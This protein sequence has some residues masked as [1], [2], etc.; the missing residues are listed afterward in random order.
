VQ[1]DAYVG[2]IARGAGIGSFGIGIGQVLRYAIQVVLAKMYG[3]A[4]L[5][6]Y[7]LGVT[8]VQAA[9]SLSQL[10]I[11]HG[12]I[13]YTAEYRARRDVSRMRGTIL[14]GLWVT[15]ALSLVLACLIFFSAGILADRIFSKPFLETIFRAFS[16]AVPFFAAMSMALS[17]TQGFQTVKYRT[18]VQH[19]LQPLIALGLIVVFYLLGM[20]LFGAVAAYVLSMAAGLV[21]SLHYLKQLFP[22]LLDRE[23]PPEFE[24]RALFSVAGPMS[25]VGLAQWV[26][27]GG[28]VL[29]VGIFATAGEVG[30]YNA[31]AGTGA[32]P[33]LVLTAFSGIF[34]PMISDLYSRGMLNDLGLLYRDVSRW[35]FTGSLAIFLLTLLLARDIMAMFGAEFVVG[36]L[37]M[38]LIAGA[39]LFSCSVGPTSRILV[40]T[41]RQKTLMVTMLGST[42][43]VLIANVVLVPLYGILG[44]AL[45]RAAGLVLL[46]AVA[47]LFVHRLLRLWPYNKHYLK[48]L[49]AGIIGVAATLLVRLMLPLPGALLPILVLGPLF[50]AGFIATLLV[51]GLSVSDRKLLRALWT[52]VLRTTLWRSS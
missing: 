21:L 19:V 52:M 15:F 25:V 18:Y 13:R 26:N 28:T 46:N 40:M 20:Q 33:V 12:V 29:V 41:D 6:F 36:W 35:I 1:Y 31:A 2:R 17:A 23:V 10:G 3:P 38:V 44:A 7:V 27:Q 16:I 49:V 24:S 50:L 43:T 34:D 39:Q 42:A 9:N 22:E 8:M 5:G 4:Q 11:N 45:A 47:I 14:L 37:A 30:I 51:L 48:P 32:L